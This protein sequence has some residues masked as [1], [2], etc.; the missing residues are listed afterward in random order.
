M[1]TL[2][3]TVR[4][5]GTGLLLLALAGCA[6]APKAPLEPA[7]ASAESTAQ[8]E[9]VSAPEPVYKPFPDG[10]LYPL[11]VAELAARS[12]HVDVALENYLQQARATRDPGIAAQATRIARYLKNPEATLEAALIWAEGEPSS[13]EARY[14]AATELTRVGRL[15]EAMTQMQALYA[16]GAGA[17]F[18]AIA[19]SALESPEADRKA[20]LAS[21]TQ[22]G[23][24]ATNDVLVAR[25]VLAQ[26]LGDNE[27]ALA[28][29]G[30]VLAEE[31]GNYQAVLIEA[32]VYQNRGET[33]KSLTRIKA[34]LE[35]EP[36]NDRLRLQY[37]R[38]LARNDLD[39]AAEQYSL[40][41]KN[42]P[43][44]AELRLSLAL[45][46]R[47]KKDYARMRTELEALLAAGR[48]EDTAHV[49]LGED[50]EREGRTD[51]A[52]DHYLAVKPSP[53]FPMAI[54]RAG[55]LQFKAGGAEAVDAAMKRFRSRWPEHETRIVLL[56]SE[57]LVGKEAYD[58]AWEL[59]SA[60]L[61]AQPG[62]PSLLYARSMVAEKRRDIP[63][64]E[65][66]LRE[67]IRLD[68]DSALALNALGYS[69]AN[70]TDRH[71][72]AL[73]LI[74]RALAL[75]PDDPAILDS[76]G[77]VQFRLGQPEKALGYLQD[78][79]AKFP[80]HEVAAHLGEVLW[81]LGRKDEAL[82]VWKKGLEGTPDSPI[83]REVIKRLGAPEPKP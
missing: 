46:Y 12:G 9:P 28:L 57:L 41:L 30:R 81:S 29:T 16:M 23:E 17:N 66:D 11:L 39:G 74:G 25:A 72:E 65:R 44:D 76:M 15:Q 48:Q 8:A 79:F 14:T 51:A 70:L 73:E 33:A 36:G 20:L 50:D 42:A 59:L 26:S 18:T 5:A 35:A 47:E 49:Y 58:A 1:H 10:A 32:Q 37:A 22:L 19:A 71:A 43:D 27:G 60:A 38:L 40:L 61:S 34:A 64:L 7:D 24:E 31:P 69:L 82:E 2:T 80:D 13:P 53:A 54:N 68:P 21:L 63:G 62:E 52:M 78:A 83:V 56:Q 4:L 67:M 77:W 6:A 45:V 3:R 55:E 75:K